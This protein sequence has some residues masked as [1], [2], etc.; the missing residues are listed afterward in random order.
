MW[1]CD[2]GETKMETGVG[3]NEAKSL[4]SAVESRVGIA[5]GQG[6]MVP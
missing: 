1:D 6:F 4:L 2:N 3:S 5:V